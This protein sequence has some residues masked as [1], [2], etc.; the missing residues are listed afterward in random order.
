[1]LIHR[2]VVLGLLASSLFAGTQSVAPLLAGSYTLPSSA[3]FNNAASF[4]ITIRIHNW[5][6]PGSAQDVNCTVAG[7]LCLNLDTLGNLRAVVSKDT[8]T[9]NPTAAM[10]VGDSIARLRRDTVG[11]TYTLEMFNPATGA[12][13]SN[14]QNITSLG[15]NNWSGS[16]GGFG[17][18][19]PTLRVAY[20]RWGNTTPPP[21]C[22]GMPL[23]TDSP[24]NILDYEFEG[25]AN[26]TSGN[27]ISLSGYGS[28]MYVAT[29]TYA[30]T[31]QGQDPMGGL[32]GLFNVNVISAN[33]LAS[34]NWV[35]CTSESVGPSGLTY[36]WTKATCPNATLSSATAAL[37]NLLDTAF[38]QCVLNGTVTDGVN[39]TSVVTTLGSVPVDGHCVVVT[40]NPTLDLI[41]KRQIRYGCNPW[42]YADQR[43]AAWAQHIGALQ[44][45]S[46]YL[47]QWNTNLGGMVTITT[48]LGVTTIVGSGTNFQ[49][50]FCNGGTSQAPNTFLIAWITDARAVGGTKRIPL[51]GSG[52]TCNTSTLI[53]LGAPYNGTL[54]TAATNIQYSLW[55]TADSWVGQSTNNNYYDN[56]LAFYTLYY[57]TG[58]TQFLTYARTLAD[59]WFTMPYFDQGLNDCNVDTCLVPRIVSYTGMIVRELDGRPDMVTGLDAWADTVSVHGFGLTWGND[60]REQAYGT[61][62]FALCGIVDTTGHKATCQ[63]YVQTAINT[64]WT[65]YRLTGGSWRD[66]LIGNTTYV[67]Q[68]FAPSA[69]LTG[70]VTISN[71]SSVLV[72]SGTGWSSASFPSNCTG[73]ECDV[74]LTPS[75]ADPSSPFLDAA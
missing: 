57:R 46:T 31:C 64:L 43:A 36:V 65:P 67:M 35:I 59:R 66:S 53:T 40:G 44:S 17:G 37:P 69:T 68:S 9:G 49:N 30:P 10:Y 2:S 55:N 74:W 54:G 42:L 71:G 12:C 73:N 34:I 27:T 7:G 1:M 58:I 14:T 5:T 39:P 21:I 60:I 11:M 24:G 50:D 33:T 18:V 51:G 41:I 45:T 26:D 8:L 6:T 19:S 62:V 72:G 20:F 15:N 25:N 75:N 52:L 48:N 63:G 22:T 61:S 3:P 70:T 16:G 47:D 4:Y 32:G 13:I 28:A 29:P 56:V 38:G 23:E